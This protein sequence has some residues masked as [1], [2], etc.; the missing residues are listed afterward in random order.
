MQLR[1]RY[2]FTGHLSSAVKAVIDPNRLTWVEEA[3]HDLATHH[4]S[5]RMIADHYADRFTSSGRTNSRPSATRRS[6]IA[7]V[8]SRSG[9]RSWAIGSRAP[10][11]PACANTSSRRPGW[12]NAGSPTT[13]VDEVYEGRD[14][15]GMPGSL[16]WI[17]DGSWP[18]DEGWPY[19]D[20]DADAGT[21]QL[22]EL[23]DVEAG[24]DD[25]L[26]A[27]HA[28]STHL[29]DSLA[30]VERAVITAGSGS[31]AGSPAAS[32]RSSTTSGSPCR[33]PGRTR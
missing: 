24:T 14:N 20:E 13:T 2:R 30:P 15:R 32:A 27:L 12:S 10:S 9:C 3:D 28:A 16:S 17:T 22:E 25:D 7:P 19:P 21:D 11:S 23:V 1:V 6:A 8:T 5:F 31:T 4:V 18:S 26:V 29:F 33:A